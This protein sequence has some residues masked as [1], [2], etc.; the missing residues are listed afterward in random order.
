MSPTDRAV[1]LDALLAGTADGASAVDRNGVIVGW[2]AAAERILGHRVDQVVGRQCHEV[3]E[4]RDSAGNLRCCE[5]CTV[6]THAR[7]CEPVHHFALMTRRRAGD[8]VWLDVSSVVLGEAAD[9]PAAWILLFRDV[10]SSHEIESIL[11]EKAVAAPA[12]LER[13]S[14]ER[15]TARELQILRLMKEGAATETITDR[16]RISRA[17][18]QNH[19]HSIFGKLDVHSRLEAVALAYRYGL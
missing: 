11:R 6:R 9:A 19:I 16:L 17:T 2:N 8:P 14:S 7:R 15:L 18:V 13:P 12:R 10:S 5:H 1:G 4:G 3:M